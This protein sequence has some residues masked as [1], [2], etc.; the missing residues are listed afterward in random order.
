MVYFFGGGGEGWAFQSAPGI[1]FWC[2]M[3]KMMGYVAKESYSGLLTFNFEI[4]MSVNLHLRRL[5]IDSF[6]NSKL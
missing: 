3:G 4:F 2:I 1:S 5:K 6:L